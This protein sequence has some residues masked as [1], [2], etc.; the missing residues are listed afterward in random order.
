MSVF[1][2]THKLVAPAGE[3]IPVMLVSQKESTRYLVVTLEDGAQESTA[4]YEWHPSEGITYKGFNLDGLNIVPLQG[5]CS[6]WPR[7]LSESWEM[8][9]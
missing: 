6:S 5:R 7:A 3:E 8:V 4:I 1:E 9:I 2:A